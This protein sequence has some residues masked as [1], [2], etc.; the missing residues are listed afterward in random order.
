LSGY[1]VRR[2]IQTLFVIIL[3]SFF[4]FSLIH[5]VPGDPVYIMM[6]ETASKE[7]I[8]AFRHELW[9]DRPFI[10]QYGHWLY[11][12]IHGDFGNSIVL[13]DSVTNI[14]AYRL[15]ITGYLALLAFLFSAVIG[16]SAG[17]ITA[18]RRGSIVDFVVTLFA[19]IGLATPIFWLGILGIYL[20]SYKLGLLPIQGFTLPTVD[21]WM[22]IKQSIMPIICL[23]LPPLALIARQARSSMLE[24]VRQDYIRTARAQGLRERVVVLKY[25]LKNAL[26]PVIT[27]LGVNTGS[28]IAGSVIVE[29]VFNIPG[30]GRLL[31]SSC[32]N[33]DFFV[34]QA[35]VL[36]IALVVCLAN[37][38]VDI[39]YSWLDPKIRYE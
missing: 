12:T 29:T 37:L 26:I 8:D 28:L 18:I 1:I 17:I 33:K 20:I 24:V 9:L 15:P 35:V 11:N 2:L 5:L 19:N 21:L 10:V 36:L 27:L 4:A 39:L 6:G 34:V 14:V 23:S 31:V 32:L 38:T 7:E 30:M 13:G 22:S 16:V 3:V 25:A